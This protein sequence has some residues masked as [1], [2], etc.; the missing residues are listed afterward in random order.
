MTN[1]NPNNVTPITAAQPTPAAKFTISASLEG[2]P[3]SIEIE[4]NAD[5]LRPRDSPPLSTPAK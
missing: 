2:F 5:K 3:I 1:Q 4:G